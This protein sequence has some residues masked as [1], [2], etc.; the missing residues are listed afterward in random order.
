ML[1]R[2]LAIILAILVLSASVAFAAGGDGPQSS[3]GKSD[4]T[5][6]T[7]S[8]EKSKSERETETH[9]DDTG[10]G[11]AKKEDTGSRS[12]TRK[13]VSKTMDKM[14]S[15]AL[16][17]SLNVVGIFAKAAASTGAIRELTLDDL[18]VIPLGNLT[19]Y[20]SNLQSVAAT[21]SVADRYIKTDLVR[22]YIIE[23]YRAG[24]WISNNLSNA[25]LLQGVGKRDWEELAT[26]T[27]NHDQA[28]LKEITKTPNLEGTCR[29]SG[30]PTKIKCGSC[31]LD[32]SYSKALPE[33]VCGGL[34]MFGP[35]SAGGEQ[36]IVQASEAVSMKEAVTHAK[37]DEE[38]SG[39]TKTLDEYV[40]WAATKGKAVEAAA[41]KRQV[42]SQSFKTTKNTQVALQAAKQK[43][44]PSKAL[45]LMGLK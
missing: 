32:I 39:I 41:V 36:I 42:L 7:E 4:D 29:W 21:N 31:I 22:E 28:G 12:S 6:R 18:L 40:K 10:G 3:T 15:S 20:R 17:R 43:D 34:V 14:K 23:L 35:D 45:G 16:N 44:D 8:G 19:G 1:R 24:E 33:L 26:L 38:F 30:Q 13:E 2:R 5:S 25:K 37:S 11:R 9:T 27:A